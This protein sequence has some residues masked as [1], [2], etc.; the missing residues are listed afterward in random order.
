MICSRVNR[1]CKDD[2]I[3]FSK[4]Y[5]GVHDRRIENVRDDVIHVAMRREITCTSLVKRGA[6]GYCECILASNIYMF[7]KPVVDCNYETL[8]K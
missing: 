8:S 3:Q 1:N 6:R 2:V 5:A 4:K 7:G